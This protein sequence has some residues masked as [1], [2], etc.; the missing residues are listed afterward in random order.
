MATDP[1]LLPATAD[2]WSCTAPADNGTVRYDG[3]D[4][5]PLTRYWWTVRLDEAG[6]EGREPASWSEPTWWETAR[7]GRPWEAEWIS[8]PVSLTAPADIPAGPSFEPVG[9]APHL[10]AQDITAWRPRRPARLTRELELGAAPQSARLCLTAL[11]LYEARINGVRVGDAHFTPGWTDYRSRV[12]YQVH[13]VTGLLA[14]GANRLEVTLAPGW[15]AGRLAWQVEVY[16]ERPALLAELTVDTD[17]DRVVIGTDS[18]W[19]CEHSD[20]LWADLILGTATDVGSRAPA[21]ND[22][23]R[24]EILADPGIELL[25]TATPPVRTVEEL[26]PATIE[27]S[28]DTLRVDMG[29]NMVGW[30]RLDLAH[31]ADAAIGVR[32]AEVLDDD[33]SLYRDNLRGAVS[34]DWYLVEGDGQHTLEP[35]FSFHGFRYAEVTGLP[36]GCEPEV[37]GVVVSQDLPRTG[38]LSTDS[39]LVD[40]L[41][42]NIEWGQRG[43][44]LEAPTD[45]PQRD[46]RLGWAADIQVFAPTAC[47]NADVRTFLARW[48]EDFRRAR[49]DGRFGLYAPHVDALGEMQA[50]AWS[51]AGVLVPW[52]LFERYGDEQL[53]VEALPSMVRWIEIVRGANPDLLWTNERGMDFGDWLA[54]FE[55]T[56]ADV[57]ATAYFARSAEITARSAAAIGE[58]QVEREHLSLWEDVKNAFN[59]AYVTSSGRIVGHTQTAYA[60]ALAFGLLPPRLV[61]A[62][63]EHLVERVTRPRTV[64]SE[65]RPGHLCC[66]FL[67]IGLALPALADHGHLELAYRLLENR[68]YPSWGFTID[69]GATTIWER[70]DGWTPGHGFQDPLMN[71]FNHYAMGSVGDFLFRYVAGL[72]PTAPGFRSVSIRPQPGGSLNEVHAVYDSVRGRFESSWKRQGEALELEVSIPTGVD[73]EIRIPGAAGG[74]V[75]E[76]GVALS[77]AEGVSGLRAERGDLVMRVGGGRYRLESS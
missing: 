26:R 28:G 54:V 47:W 62:A 13:D 36:A 37:T 60:L 44:F 5:E 41:Q 14:A 70:W 38:W 48:L 64:S 72:Q 35:R 27:R 11:G 50:P 6:G 24:A 21:R 65:F 61:P 76:G 66:G 8:A 49:R 55:E 32:H 33:G 16:G 15:Y 25:G 71:S 23:H 59:E 42:H 68:S 43:N 77:E 56:P 12:Q 4:L 75:T 20:L 1:S 2:V 10:Q 39:D 51:D 53:L 31:A 67:G 19:Q 18:A 73:A 9:P 17:G 57:V 3:P 58:R 74:E 69:K 22:R 40:Q 46:E 7:M 29:Q 34:E 45:C 30:L 52:T 63:V